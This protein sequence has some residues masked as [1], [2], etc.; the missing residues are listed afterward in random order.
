MR[1]TIDAFRR[2]RGGAG[3]RSASRASAA[4]KAW[5]GLLLA[6]LLPLLAV[7]QSTPS[8]TVLRNVAQVAYSV[9][10][11]ARTTLTNEVALR[12]E[13]AASR[14][15]VALARYAASVADVALRAT[16]G[17]T[18]CLGSAGLVS[19]A[20]PSVAGVG[21]IDAASPLPL[22][23]TGAVHAGDA[24]FVRVDDADQNRDPAVRESVDV[25]VGS[26]D[27]GDVET[28]RLGETGPDTGIFVGFVPSR[29]GA[30]S[31]GSCVL[32]LARDSALD[33]SYADP[34][35]PA[36]TSSAA[37]LVDPFGVLFD[38]TT[39]QPVDGARVRL[40]TAAGAPAVV[41]GDDGVSRYPSEM[42]TGQAVTDS[43]GTTYRLPAGVY[44]FPLVAS[45]SYRL[46]VEPADG[47]V[48]ASAASVAEL[49]QLPGAPFRLGEGSFGREFAVA[50]PVVTAVDVPLDPQGGSLLLQKTANVKVAAVG[51]FVAWDLVLQNGGV[52]AA[53]RDVEVRDR[54][55]RGVR[56]RAGTVRVDGKPV[57]DPVV[58]DG[59]ESLRFRLARLG[60]GATV[61]IRY[62]TELTVAVRGDEVL[63]TAI[64]TAS[65]GVSSDEAQ[66]RVRVHDDLF[67]QRGFIAGRVF[68]GACDVDP[69]VARGVEGV[70]VYLE[71]GR[72]AVT[73]REGRYHFD[74]VTPGTHV[75]QADVARGGMPLEAL[76]CLGDS[77]H[78]GR[79]YSQFVEL[80]AGALRRVDFRLAP[81]A[82]RQD[83]AA[84]TAGEAS[85]PNG[86]AGAQPPGG[87]PPAAPLEDDFQADVE[88]L[89]PGVRFL[90]PAE[91]A[92]PAIASLRIAIAHAP[93]QQ[94]VLSVNGDPVSP[95]NFDGAETNRA[96]TV[97]VSRWRGVD[98]SDGPNE[99]VA[100][101]RAAN[102]AVMTRLTRR[103]HYGGGP[104]RAEFDRAASTL[105]A[106]GRTR[107]IVVLKLFD[108]W[109]R[110][111][112]PGA[113][114]TFEVGAPYRSWAEVQALDDN[115]LL[116]TGPREP[117]FEVGPHGT[118]RLELE[119]TTQAG[120]VTLRLRFNE[121][122]A[123]EVR[124]WL[125]P[126]ARDWIMV[127]I[128]SGTA[129]WNRI[130]GSAEPLDEAGAP[131]EE[132]FD[133]A[134]RLAFFAKGRI[135]GDALLTLAYDSARDTRAAR[136]RLQGVV[137]PDQY[138]L[139]YADGTEPRAEAASAEKLYLKLERRQYVAMFGDFAT[140]FT[141][142][143]LARYDRSLT[144]L[145][146]DYVGE[147][148]GAS[149]FAA[150]TDL[151][152]GR[153]EL[154]GDGTSGLYRLSR[155][156]I[157][158][159]SD[160]IRIEVRDRFRTEVVVESRELARFLDYRLDY[161]TG[162]LFFKEPVPSRDDRFNPV[163]I[164]AE[165]ET[166]GTGQEVTTAGARGTLRSDDG[167]LEAGL[168]LVNDGAVAG[169]TQLAGADLRWYLAPATEFRAELARSRSDDP[170]RA[171]SA[172]AYL[173]ELKHVTER[174]EALAYLREQQQGFGVG[175]QLSTEGGTRKT[176]VDL[177]W[178]I[179][180]VWSVEGQLLAQH[181]LATEADRQL[182][183][184]EV[185]YELETVG[186]GLGLRHVADDVPGEGTRRSE[187]AF[188]TGNVDLF[189]RRITLRGSAD[190][191][192]GGAGG[193][194]S[195]DY[196]ARTL[197]GVDWHVR[198]D[199]DL[200]TEWEHGSGA[201]L[202]SD[203]T[204]VGVRAKPWERTQVV[205]SVNQQSTEYGPRSFAN[206]GLTQG[207]RVNERWTFDVG[208]DQSNTIRGPGVA[209]LLSDRAPLA[210]GTVGLSGGNGSSGVVGSSLATGSL[211]GTTA[212]EDFLATFVGTQYHDEDWTL[213]SRAERR[214]ADSG[215]RWS[216]TGGW[217]REQSAG[218]SLSMSLQHLDSTSRLAGPDEARTELRFA[219]AWRPADSRWI[220]FNRTDL[221]RERRDYAAS[222]E[223]TLRWVDNLHANW[224]PRADQQVGLQLGF[225]RVIGSFDEL[226][227]AGTTLL[228]AGDWRVDLPWRAFGR[229]LDTGLHAARIESREAGVARSSFGF[230]V[231]ISPAT[232]CWISVGYNVV[233]FHDADFS[234]AR[235]TERGPYVA[236]RI[237]ADQD[238]FKDLRLDS[239]RAPR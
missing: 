121:R 127:G 194:A 220:I 50:A 124:A 7:A 63:N 45:G 32:D 200:F 199:V 167:K 206:F 106:D 107:P 132:G 28:L 77:R 131:V 216:F 112:R 113:L 171:A 157:V 65:G 225:R 73:D 84:A 219:W 11:E 229:A 212:T 12:T 143:E 175:Q 68:E 203:M 61:R 126:S 67:T 146:A 135:R 82:S 99:L 10:G 233:G 222:V 191:S 48:F 218:H 150:R 205:S 31:S 8:G 83:A 221:A 75:V 71:D 27:T 70:A 16:A 204:R 60:P 174:L 238:T 116:A 138:Y 23:E 211:G 115:P 210:S 92:T 104:V 33:V 94:V 114:G 151:G 228:L 170:L 168:S 49:Q 148:V 155:A 162:E 102:G 163:F 14:G 24:I 144:G 125:E 9:E 160:R 41:F 224:Q 40:V 76:D 123:Q 55:P 58:E 178:K 69:R 42:I 26:R 90:A 128:A 78:A 208:L 164:V 38:S 223:E 101:V 187:Q 232:N 110:P 166:Q 235:Y 181:S 43:G 51:D 4:V 136:R 198:D 97:S 185:R 189:D 137:D 139:L 30:G 154:R 81:G 100:E 236:V 20:A 186:A 95:L 103:V 91:D 231:G 149:G 119:P 141:V 47:H 53:I 180:P 59:G 161:A 209:P 80:R 165:Y 213:T 118:A 176:G 179:D 120:T 156:P 19:L 147:R 46:V 6:G 184:A 15:R 62:V 25:R 79:A 74:D 37:G 196:P 29:I 22:A 1:V 172:T 158:A 193:D 142:A 13:P 64:A 66:A 159:G 105:V 57:A 195:V 140:G 89:D 215:V 214:S 35:D 36:D 234:A 153:D 93:D 44:R 129:A 152:F 227:L 133:G 86:L 173:A 111:A 88:T 52:R 85:P 17:P 87:G 122:Q 207:F 192:L 108:A 201:A 182:A 134:G 21:A 177:R 72:Y 239:L 145:K 54:L 197:L 117:N 188:V 190:A 237:K 18:Q 98:L 34:R 217:Y 109:G 56:F 3:N 5:P 39:G 96:R 183:E 230:D 202:R 169:D 226:R 130:S 2:A